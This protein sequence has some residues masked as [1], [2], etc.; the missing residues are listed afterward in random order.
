MDEIDIKKQLKINKHRQEIIDALL[1]V[2]KHSNLIQAIKALSSDAKNEI[3]ERF[4]LN[5]MQAAAIMDLKKPISDI[6]EEKILEEKANLEKIEIELK[7][8]LS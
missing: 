5:S 3:M 6:P 1:S 8:C 7:S 4:H 2:H